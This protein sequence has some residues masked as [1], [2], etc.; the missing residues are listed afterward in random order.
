M[1]ISK[2]SALSINVLSIFE[3]YDLNGAQYFSE[4]NHFYLQQHLKD[5]L[6]FLQQYIN[7]DILWYSIF[8]ILF[9]IFKIF[10]LL[11]STAL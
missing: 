8:A 3:N 7:V 5:L 2:S 6:S 4:L 9:S 1:V 11:N 10:H